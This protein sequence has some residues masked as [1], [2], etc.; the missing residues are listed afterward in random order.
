[1]NTRYDAALDGVA[2]SSLDPVIYVLDVRE[3][4]SE[5]V[6]TASARAAGDGS[7]VTR[8]AR[9][10]L[11]VQVSAEIHEA[12]VGRRQE[13][14]SRIAAWARGSRLTVGHRPGQYLTVT[15]TELPTV[16]TLRW[17][18]PISLTFTAY[19]V[20]FWQAAATAS[21]SVSGAN[22]GMSL[23]NP[24]T[25]EVPL[26]AEVYNTSGSVADSVSILLG[27]QKLNFTS[28]RLAAR[29][30]LMIAHDAAGR[31]HLAIRTENGTTRSAYS[32]RTPDSADEL[33]LP[34]G[35]SVVT[36][37]S[38]KAQRW[39]LKVRGRWH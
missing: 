23:A 6:M 25:A 8:Q 20:P 36:V 5:R 32:C 2:L 16:S 4:A 17:T 13:I 29:E 38:D 1:M 18:E 34:P 22:A 39:T 14:I 30:T 7:H 37:A 31:L 3:E 15:C 10:S 26:E 9:L 35:D 24:G 21:T 28:L 33:M 19:D 11:S 12:D 27:A